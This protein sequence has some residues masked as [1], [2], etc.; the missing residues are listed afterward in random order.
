MGE[1]E[2][3][4]TAKGTKMGVKKAY[5]RHNHYKESLNITT[6]EHITKIK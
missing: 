4:Q 3:K 5:L 6:L 2:E 1:S